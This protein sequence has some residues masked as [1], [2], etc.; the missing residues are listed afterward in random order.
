MKGEVGYAL[1]SG[2]GL[3]RGRCIG[4]R[5]ELVDLALGMAVDDAGDDVGEVGLRV[6]GVELASL[7]RTANY[8]ERWYF[9]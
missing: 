6:D 1:F 5:Q 7:C 4:P 2:H 9:P 8:A 3:E